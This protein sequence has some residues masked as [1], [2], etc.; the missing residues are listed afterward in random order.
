MKTRARILDAF[1]QNEVG[2]MIFIGIYQPE[3]FR[4][5]MKPMQLR[6]QTE[7][8][9]RWINQKDSSFSLQNPES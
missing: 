5:Q 1:Y 3:T 4:L 2:R 7:H 8:L 6:H 9:R